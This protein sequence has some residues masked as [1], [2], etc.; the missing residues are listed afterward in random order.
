ML[1]V[2]QIK[3]IISSQKANLEIPGGRELAIQEIKLLLDKLVTFANDLYIDDTIVSYNQMW[4]STAPH[5]KLIDHI[6]IENIFQLYYV[7]NIPLYAQPYNGDYL[8]TSKSYK[9]YTFAEIVPKDVYNA[10]YSD[11]VTHVHSTDIFIP[12]NYK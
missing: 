10:I 2:D 3:S 1:T 5:L 11:I 4:Y 8:I 7:M 6:E 9:N 12:Y